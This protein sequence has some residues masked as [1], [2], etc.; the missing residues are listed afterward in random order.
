MTMIRTRDVNGCCDSTSAGQRQAVSICTI[1]GNGCFDQPW[2]E[3]S[4][5]GDSQI[6]SQMT[7]TVYKLS[8]SR[9]SVMAS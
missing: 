7:V 1:Y 5:L 4:R 8:D 2:P 6:I 3:S 9:V